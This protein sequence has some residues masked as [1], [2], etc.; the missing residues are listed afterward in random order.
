[1]IVYQVI[2]PEFLGPEGV[3]FKRTY[4]E[5]VTEKDKALAAYP[6]ADVR[7]IQVELVKLPVPE[8]TLALLNRKDYSK[9][10]RQLWPPLKVT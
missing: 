9:E 6:D 8:L 2:G 5:C 1:M 4:K 10:S 3:A 7:I